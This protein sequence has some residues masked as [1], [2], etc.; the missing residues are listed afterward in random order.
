VFLVELFTIARVWNKFKCPS[1]VNREI[2]YG[3]HTLVVYSH[4]HCWSDWGGRGR[5]KENDGMGNST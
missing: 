5:G 1:M 3:I 4:I 2:K